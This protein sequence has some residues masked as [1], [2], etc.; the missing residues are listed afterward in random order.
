MY[1]KGRALLYKRGSAIPRA[2][3]CCRRAVILDPMYAQA[4]A[5]LAESYI[6]LGYYGFTPA[7]ESMPKGLEAAERAVAIDAA[8]AEAHCALAMASLMGTWDREEARREFLRSIELNPKYLMARTWYAFF[9]LQLSEG[10]LREG[11]TQAK[12]ALVSDPLSCYAHTMYAWTCVAAGNTAEAIQAARRAIEID[13]ESY[14][15]HFAL[16]EALR[17]H[18]ELAESIAVGQSALAMSGRHAW[19]MICS[20]L[21]FADWCKSAEADAVYC[22]ML[23]RARYQYVAPGTLA[24]AA[25]AAAREDDAVRHAREAFEARDPTY[26]VFLSRYSTLSVR[27]YTYSGFREIIALMGR[28]AWLEN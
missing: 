5:E 13:S 6:G 24:I 8:L 15:A 3:E 11:M 14:I 26:Q 12:V 23:A 2:L 16:Q 22:E 20:A 18:G 4:W 17:S 19:A 25:S 28:S 10:Q 1:V 21:T 7:S 27:L 9:Y